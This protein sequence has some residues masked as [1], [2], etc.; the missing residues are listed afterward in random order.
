MGE[1]M[2]RSKRIFQT[3]VKSFEEAFPTLEGAVLEYIE[4]E[5]GEPKGGRRKFDL[6]RERGGVLRCGNRLCYRGGYEIDEEVHKMLPEGL[7][8]KHIDL[9]CRGDEGTPKGGRIGRSCAWSIEGTLTLK[10]KAPT[11]PASAVEQGKS[12]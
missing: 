3:Q 10:F 5:Y 11:N 7:T 1:P 2:D 8:A 4:F 9:S 6:R 12:G